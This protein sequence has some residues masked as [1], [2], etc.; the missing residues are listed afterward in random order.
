MTKSTPKRRTTATLLLLTL[1]ICASLPSLVAN[2]GA[3]PLISTRAGLGVRTVRE[4]SVLHRAPIVT[5]FENRF[6]PGNLSTG[7]FL[8]EDSVATLYGYFLHTSRAGSGTRLNAVAGSAVLLPQTIS[9]NTSA[10]GSKGYLQSFTVAATSDSNLP[11]TYSSAGACTNVDDLFTMTSGSGTC[12]VMYDQPGDG[13]YDPASQVT[14]NVTATKISQAALTLSGVPSSAAVNSNFTVTPGGGS[15]SASLVVSTAGVCSASGNQI[16]MTS[17]T[18]TCTVKVNRA[19]DS[20]YDAAAEVSHDATATKL[21]QAALT[22][23]G[24]PAT[25]AFN[26]SFTV[27][28]GGGSSSAPFV[29]STTG[30]CSASGNDITMTS[31]TGTCTVKVN[32]AGDATYEDAAEVSDTADATKISQA[33]LTLSGVPSSAAVNSNF[34]VTP[35][36]GSSSA[37]LVVSTAGVC[38]AS[39]NQITMTSGTGTCTVKVNRAGDNNYDAAAE[40]SHDATATKLSQAALTIGG[41]PATA[42]FNSSFT[43]TPGGGSSSAPFVVST[44]GPCSASGN[45]ITMTSGTGTCTVKVNRAGDATYEDA[46]EV[47]DTADATKISQAALT[48]SG[49]PSSAAVNSN[50]TVTPGGGSSSASLVV[51]TAGVCSASGNQITMTSGTGTCTVKVNRAG[52]SNYDAAS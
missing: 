28:P 27:T 25:A 30:P 18:G 2:V 4:G 39:G 37:S 19:G 16:T 29:V 20:N 50:F 49:V 32:R 51:S 40:V 38:S 24:V 12:T 45:D 31:G 41:V 23:G 6:S 34:T 14:E 1:T 9:V 43:V 5:H 52:D 36:G 17:G 8:T 44:T 10:P 7:N 3:R 48:L 47:S 33:A 15:S 11:I 42:A 26:S 22:I 35:G 13:T 46:A 21:S